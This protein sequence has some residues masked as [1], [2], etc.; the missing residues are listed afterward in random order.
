MYNN[1]GLVESFNLGFKIVSYSIVCAGIAII[2]AFLW[3]IGSKEQDDLR[4]E[5]WTINN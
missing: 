3:N 5:Y 1:N 4:K 2:A